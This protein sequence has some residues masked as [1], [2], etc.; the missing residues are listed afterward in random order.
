MRRGPGS[1]MDIYSEGVHQ[2]YGFGPEK[3]YGNVRAQQNLTKATAWQ[4][5]W[6]DTKVKGMIVL[7]FWRTIHM[8][9]PL[10]YRPLCLCDPKSMDRKDVVN[11]AL[12]GYRSCR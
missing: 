6:D 10:R 4:K 11:I 2:D 12:S 8:D 9:E 3:F 5:K 7:C 1:K